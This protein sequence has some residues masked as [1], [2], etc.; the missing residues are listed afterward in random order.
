MTEDSYQTLSAIRDKKVPTH[1]QYIEKVLSKIVKGERILDIGGAEGF[2][3]YLAKKYGAKSA[4]CIEKSA[5]R[6]KRG[7]KY[8][9]GSKFVYG[10][11]MD[12]LDMITCADIIIMSRVLYY[13]TDL[14]INKLFNVISKEQT[15]LIRGRWDHK[16]KLKHPDDIVRLLNEYG[17]HGKKLEDDW[18]MGTGYGDNRDLKWKITEAPKFN[19]KFI[20]EAIAFVQT[21]I[22]GKRI[23]DVGVRDGYSTEYWNRLGYDCLGTELIDGFI[24]HA[25]KRKRNVIF[26]D[27]IHTKLN[28]LRYK[29]DVV[30]CR[31]VLEHTEHPNTAVKNFIKLLKEG[32][33]LIIFVP[34]ESKGNFETIRKRQKHL[35]YFPDIPYFKRFIKK[36]NL[37]TIFL[38]E[39]EKYVKFDQ[40]EIIYIGQKT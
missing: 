3:C 11:I 36:F 37:K 2:L 40:K 4:L 17:F 9:E 25:Q 38:D 33:Y 26:D 16:G 5:Y 1:Y 31:H 6:I 20:E 24:K 15:L 29:F 23:L 19:H 30:Y 35:C 32:S 34:I 7:M 27:M 28:D 21:K 22:K 8:I 13:L 10:N 12:N 39:G 18:V 14:E